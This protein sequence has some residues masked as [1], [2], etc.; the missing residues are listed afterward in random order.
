MRSWNRQSVEITLSPKEAEDLVAWLEESASDLSR[1]QV[2]FR[3]AASLKA[4]LA[5]RDN[6]S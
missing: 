1:D 6:R 3:L 2:A 4:A 5:P